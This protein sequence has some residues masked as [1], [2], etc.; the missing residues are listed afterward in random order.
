M[1]KEITIFWF[2][3]A[4]GWE[5]VSQ[6]HFL[7]EVLPSRQRVRMQF[8]YSSSAIPTIL[9]GQPP[10][11]H[12]HLG[13][14]RYAPETSP[15]RG[16]GR[17]APLLKPAAL[18][19]RGRVRHWISKVLGRMLGFTGYFQVYQVPFAKLAYLDY[20]EK[21]DLFVPGGMGAVENLAD[22]LLRSGQPFH[23][24]DWRLG[25]RRNLAAARAAVEQG[26]HFLF[27]YT[28]ELDGILHQTPS[29][30]APTVQEKL[31]W[32]RQELENLLATCRQCGK[33]PR[34]TIIS[35]HGMSPLTRTVDLKAAVEAT[36]LVF[37]ADYGAC[38]DSTMFRVNFLKPGVEEIIR[39]ALQPFAEFGHW[40]SLDEEKGYG[41]YRTD[42]RFGDAIFL[43]EPGVQIVPSDM[44]LK[45]LNGMHGYAPED[46]DSYAAI[47]SNAEIPSEI[48]QVSDYFDWMI[49]AAG[50]E[51]K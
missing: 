24:S 23:I 38:Y 37:G 33:T 15:F 39:N 31:A 42:R 28:A 32:Y 27:I 18:W 13:L 19:N 14:F 26:A 30:Q 12:G 51:G 3:D 17:L 48:Q 40:L 4:L 41:I 36:G 7:E 49:K 50:M 8:G 29:A 6:T 16:L 46:Q 44:G 21:Q 1:S 47:L 34:L 43:M 10:A 11:V 20:C 22:R 9:S 2:V 5:I 45:P 25:D 35:D